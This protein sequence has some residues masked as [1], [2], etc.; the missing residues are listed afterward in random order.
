MEYQLEDKLKCLISSLKDYMNFTNVPELKHK[1]IFLLGQIA[2]LLKNIK[3]YRT[4]IERNKN[5]LNMMSS[6]YIGTK[7]RINCLKNRRLNP[8]ENATLYQQIEEE[9]SIDEE[10]LC[11]DESLVKDNTYMDAI[12]Y[13]IQIYELYLAKSSRRLESAQSEYDI[14]YKE[15]YETH[16][17][18]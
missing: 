15:I 6:H 3:F 5:I 12:K 16:K 9:Q 14:L 18:S 1:I 2:I 8:D 17:L 4:K 7:E 13:N 10:I 11:L